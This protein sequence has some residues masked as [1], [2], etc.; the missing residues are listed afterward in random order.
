MK[1]NKITCKSNKLADIR[2]YIA[3]CSSVVRDSTPKSAEKLFVRLLSESY[4]EK[5]SRPF[6]FIPCRLK[7]NTEIPDTVRQLFGFF[8][9]TGHYFTNA[10]ELLNWDWSLK[11]VLAHVNFDNYEVFRCEAPYMVYQQLSTH[12][13]LTTISHSRRYTDGKST[14]FKPKEC[15][16][17][18]QVTWDVGVGEVWSPNELKR[19]MRECGVV[20]KEVLNR[21]ADML[22]MRS[23]IIGGYTNNP[24]AWEHFIN[25]RTD[26]HTQAESRE[27]VKK[28]KEL[29]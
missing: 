10:R 25:Q 27:L 20:H 5:P 13:Q 29:L 28:I 8:D 17:I 21:G 14:Y 12:V 7:N 18:E 16:K 24:N 1:V 4:G 3:E 15:S 22:Q 6:E 9:D 11:K 2:E 26:S 23:F 19:R